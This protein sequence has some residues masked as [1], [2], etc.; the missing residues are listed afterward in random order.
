MIEARFEIST[1]YTSW[2]IYP[3]L[4]L[5]KLKIEKVE[6][7]KNLEPVRDTVFVKQRLIENLAKSGK[8]IDLYKIS[9]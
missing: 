3:N 4:N 9:I 2:L 1:K 5:L 8:F 6:L 7:F